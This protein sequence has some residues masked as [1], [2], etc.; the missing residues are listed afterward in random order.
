MN[1]VA[2]EYLPR[3]AGPDVLG[4]DVAVLD[5]LKAHGEYELLAGADVVAHDPQAHVVIR[6]GDP[7]W[8]PRFYSPAVAVVALYEDE[9]PRLASAFSVARDLNPPVH[10][11]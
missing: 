1:D 5:V 10:I 7:F 6:G 9:L 8:P 4:T 11:L 3:D 2:G